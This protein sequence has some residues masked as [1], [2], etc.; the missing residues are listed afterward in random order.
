MDDLETHVKLVMV[1]REGHNKGTM[2]D[3]WR[4][5]TGDDVD[6][7]GEWNQYESMDDSSYNALNK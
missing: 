4:G 1:S 2:G 6:S 7:R 5:R 3:S